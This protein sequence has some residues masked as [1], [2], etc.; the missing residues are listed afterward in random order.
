MFEK[1]IGCGKLRPANTN[2]L[3]Y[4]FMFPGGPWRTPHGRVGE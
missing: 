1:K 4:E 3:K 2:G